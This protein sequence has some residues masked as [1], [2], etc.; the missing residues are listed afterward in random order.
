MSTVLGE[1]SSIERKIVQMHAPVISNVEVI[2]RHNVI[3]CHAPE[4]ARQAQPGQFVNAFASGVVT[5]ILRKPFSVFQADTDAGTISLLYQIHGAT[6]LGMAGKREGD[7]LDI[8]GPL[9]GSVFKADPEAAHTHVMVGGGYGVPP[10]VFLAQRLRTANSKS[11][12]RFIVGARSKD[13]LLCEAELAGVKVE[14]DFCTEDGSNGA[15]GR[16]TDVLA[17]I[18]ESGINAQV[19]TCGPTPMMRAVAEMCGGLNVPCQVSLEVPMPCG[20]GVCMGCVVDLT[21]DSRVRA[22]LEGPVF[23]AARVTWK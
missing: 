6:T 4:I 12:I 20:I 23:D 22:C 8:V 13:L 2:A 17:R 7:T 16:V 5:N 1:R 10:L 19:Y 9:G 14:A 21:D 15:P 11:F 18:L 3:T